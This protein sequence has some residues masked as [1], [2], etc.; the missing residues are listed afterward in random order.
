MSLGHPDVI[1][2][3]AGP[4]GTVAAYDLARS[5]AKVLLVEKRAFPRDKACG[6]VV[7]LDAI[8]L[9]EDLGLGPRLQN[10]FGWDECV[11]TSPKGRQVSCRGSANLEGRHGIVARRVELDM[12]LAERAVAAGAELVE[13]CAVQGAIVEDGVCKALRLERAGKVLEVRAP[14]VIAADGH[15]SAV[16]RSLGL[17]H[18]PEVTAFAIRGYF[19]IDGRSEAHRPAIELHLD[20]R[21][22]PGYGW[23]FPV[24]PTVANVGVGILA[25]PMVRRKLKL[26]DLL[27]AFTSSNAFVRERLARAR[28]I[29]R[30]RG[31][32]LPMGPGPSHTV[33]ANCLFVGDAAGFVDALTGEGIA[34]AMHSGRLAATVAIQALGAACFEAKTLANYD[35]LC[36][37]RFGS[38]MRT[39]WWLQRALGSGFFIDRLVSGAAKRPALQAALFDMIAGVLPKSEALR[40]MNLAR[41]FL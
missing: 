19:E 18:R 33:R 14:L 3:G 6:D 21:L 1:V 13:H 5:G 29:G 32:P 38:S 2:A 17:A 16:G 22:L 30:L 35:R 9:L 4:G 34:A 7:S 37:R 26:T 28:P 40:P 27:S 39:A 41:A 8:E 12:A 23:Y 15:S 24:S 36:R 11:L 10:W 20:R 31:A 25:G